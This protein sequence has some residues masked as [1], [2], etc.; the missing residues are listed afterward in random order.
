M[1]PVITAV[2]TT[3]L[4]DVFIP[5]L[6]CRQI[7]FSRAIVDTIVGIFLSSRSSNSQAG[8]RTLNPGLNRKLSRD[9]EANLLCIPVSFVA[10]LVL[11][12][13]LVPLGVDA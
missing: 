6:R 11:G 3:I 5:M 12:L 13:L 2:D 4:L 7:G 8:T 10:I 9:E 1:R